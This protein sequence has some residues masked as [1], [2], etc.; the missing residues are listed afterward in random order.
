MPKS[1][2]A[3]TDT[4]KATPESGVHPDIRKQLAWDI[5]PIGI[6]NLQPGDLADILNHPHREHIYLPKSDQKA[7]KD[8]RNLVNNQ[9]RNFSRDKYFKQVKLRF[10]APKNLATSDSNQEAEVG[11]SF[12]RFRDNN[13]CIIDSDS[14]AELEATPTKRHKYSKPEVSKPSLPKPDTTNKRKRIDETDKMSDVH[15]RFPNAHIIK[16]DIDHP[17]RN[18]E[19]QVFKLR[20][21]EGAKAGV[22]V[23]CYDIQ[24]NADIREILSSTTDNLKARQVSDNHVLVQV[25]AMPFT[26]TADRAEHAEAVKNNKNRTE[27]VKAHDIAI[28]AYSNDEDR[29]VKELLLE[30][31]ESEELSTKLMHN[32]T[33]GDTIPMEMVVIK[34]S[35]PFPNPNNPTEYILPRISWKIGIKETLERQTGFNA[36]APKKTAAQL[37]LDEA[38]KGFSGMSI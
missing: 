18:R 35:V 21:V 33:Q 23:D 12:K 8:I 32:D 34:C 11:E 28:N 22:C 25:T 4:T 1:K 29:H 38:M 19:V 24:Y 17:E 15:K 16:V 26:Q 6:R 37:A 5:E 27:I 10:K 7:R 30:F 36:P 2:T 9:W 13:N 20:D 14:E 31:D 3:T